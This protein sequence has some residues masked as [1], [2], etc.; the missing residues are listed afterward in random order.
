LKYVH[1]DN[2]VLQ[3][4]AAECEKLK[5]KQLFMFL[6][7]QD[8]DSR[9]DFK[10]SLW[11]LNEILKDDFDQFDT[12]K[13]REK[14]FIRQRQDTE[15]HR[16]KITEKIQMMKTQGRP[17]K[18]WN[19]IEVMAGS[20]EMNPGLKLAVD[21]LDREL[22]ECTHKVDSIRKDIDKNFEEDGELNVS[23]VKE[24]LTQIKIWVK[25]TG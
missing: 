23:Q 3:L 21:R 15:V 9:P 8:S 14:A 12:E 10:K 24:E 7:A 11:E 19:A 20:T 4:R 16:Q 22:K 1:Q 5:L 25:Q 2:E 13:L 17:Q 18:M 6:C